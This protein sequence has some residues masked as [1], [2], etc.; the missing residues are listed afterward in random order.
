MVTLI[1]IIN[2]VPSK[3]D[4]YK[5]NKEK[6]NS[7]V[8]SGVVSVRLNGVIVDMCSSLGSFFS[9]S[10]YRNRS[11]FSNDISLMNEGFSLVLAKKS[12]LS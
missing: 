12:L 8:F 5:R 2:Y 4:V 1:M 11:E 3:K 10:S 9:T 7:T 6:K